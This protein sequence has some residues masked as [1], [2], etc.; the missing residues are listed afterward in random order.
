[1]FK[2]T[3]LR[4]DPWN[5]LAPST[6]NNGPQGRGGEALDCVECLVYG[7]GGASKKT[8][9]Y[10]VVLY[11]S[12]DNPKAGHLINRRVVGRAKGRHDDP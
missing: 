2:G 12:L 4:G 8:G 7:E 1:M 5:K 9:A 10:F 6:S 3:A 11:H